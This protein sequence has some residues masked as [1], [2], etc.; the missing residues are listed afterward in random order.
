MIFDVRTLW[1]DGRDQH[2]TGHFKKNKSQTEPNGEKLFD[3]I[4]SCLIKVENYVIW[5]SSIPGFSARGQ[6]CKTSPTMFVCMLAGFFP[7]PNGNFFVSFWEFFRG[8]TIFWCRNPKTWN[9]PSIELALVQHISGRSSC[10]IP[11]AYCLLVKKLELFGETSRNN[12]VKIKWPHIDARHMAH[13]SHMTPYLTAL[14]LD[15]VSFT[16]DLWQWFKPILTQIVSDSVS[17]GLLLI[18]DS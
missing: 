18:E 8:S 1:S 16:Y 10:W 3:V 11:T 9:N 6:Y 4:K 2:S 17:C 7:Q 13:M 14:P 5:P 12:Q 15:H